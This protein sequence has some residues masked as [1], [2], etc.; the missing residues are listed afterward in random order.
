MVEIF[1]SVHHLVRE[2]ALSKAL[3]TLLDRR[4]GRLHKNFSAYPNHAWYLVGDIYLK[5]KKF[6]LAAKAFKRSVF[7]RAE[8]KDALLALGFSYSE[9][10]QPR[11]AKNIL[12]KGKQLF[13]RDIRIKYNL[14]NA[15]FDLNDFAAAAK[16]YV[17]L[18]K[19]KDEFIAAAS[20]KNLRAIQKKLKKGDQ[21]H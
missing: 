8:D 1:D 6:D 18:Q 7:Y 20:K 10:K 15:Y 21:L 13:P 12:E 3:W 17:S 4:S 11:K 9:N 2:N 5:A 14:A 19:C 16:L